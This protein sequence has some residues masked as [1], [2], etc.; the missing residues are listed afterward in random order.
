MFAALCWHAGA[1]KNVDKFDSAACD[2]VNKIE[3]AS[4]VGPET[5]LCPIIIGFTFVISN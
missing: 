5:I 2:N 4:D 3:N 1:S